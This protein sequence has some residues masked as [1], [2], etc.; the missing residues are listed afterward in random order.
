MRRREFIALLGGVTAAWP[1][2]VEA[3]VTSPNIL[4]AF[5]GPG[6]KTTSGR[7]Y[8]GFFEGMREFGYQLDRDY[9]F[10]GRY[11]DGDLSRLPSLAEELVH[12]KPNVI[13]TGTSPGA[14]AAKQF[15]TSIPIVAVTLTDPIGMGVVA[16]E[17]HPDTN[18]T[19]TLIRL[20]GMTGKQLEIG[21]DLVPGVKKIGVLINPTNPSNMVQLEDL[22]SV[23]STKGMIF[24]IIQ[25]LEPDGL[26]SAFQQLVSEQ[27]E[28]V[29]V[30][31][32]VM[33]VNIRRQ[34]AAFALVAR[35]PTVF[36]LR[37]HV[38]AGGLVSYGTNLRANFRRAAYF[39]DR[40]LK[41][42]KPADLPIEFLPKLELVINLATA[43]ALSL[44]V[45]E[46]VLSRTDEVIE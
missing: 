27:V 9:R 18:V 23:P 7:F 34:I 19:G 1:F 36:N 22:K 2:V 20:A 28:I 37:E 29:L 26:A 12:L 4:I 42:D 38:E 46:S 15:T 10:E 21:L 35:L 6:S 40:I 16:S 41:G 44:K 3:Q 32:D 43:K 13:V 39:V 24:A 25:V 17:A 45:P 8:D 30:M 31:N 14:L 5:L 11:A 33:L